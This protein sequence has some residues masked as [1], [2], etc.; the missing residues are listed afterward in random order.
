[1]QKSRILDEYARESATKDSDLSVVATGNVAIM[2]RLVGEERAQV[3]GTDREMKGAARVPVSVAGDEAFWVGT[4][5]GA[6][7]SLRIR[8][9]GRAGSRRDD[10]ASDRHP[11]VWGGA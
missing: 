1:M 4:S 9:L 2:K 10:L 8:P 5:G 7:S 6:V 3:S 11:M